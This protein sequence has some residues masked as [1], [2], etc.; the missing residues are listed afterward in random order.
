LHSLWVLLEIRLEVGWVS[1][2]RPPTGIHPIGW[3]P[4]IEFDTYQ[5]QWDP[6]NNHVGINVNSIVSQTNRTWHNRLT[7][8]D[9]YGATISYNGISKETSS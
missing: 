2:T 3:W 7:S 1:S 6:S 4:W 5:D 8:G 9:I